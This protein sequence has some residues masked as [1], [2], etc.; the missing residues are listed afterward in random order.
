MHAPADFAPVL[1]EKRPAAH[2]VHTCAL[3]GAQ[4]P[5]AHAVHDAAAALLLPDGP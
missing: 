5:A 3:P 1:P 4:R 2:A